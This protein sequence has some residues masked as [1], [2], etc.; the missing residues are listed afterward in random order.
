KLT[1]A[2]GVFELNVNNSWAVIQ[3]SMDGYVEK[4]V[5]VL[6]DQAMQ[7]KIYPVGYNSNFESTE[8][9]FGDN[10][11]LF[12]AGS[13]Q[14]AMINAWEQNSETITSY[15]QGKLS[16]VNVVRKSGTPSMGAN[17]FIRN[18]GSL[19]AQNQPLYIVD[20]VVYNAEMLTPSITSGHENNPLQHIDIRDIQ[21]VTVLKDAVST[22]IYGARAANGIVVINTTH[23]KELATKIDLQVR[24]GYNFSP[25]AIPMMKSYNYRSYLNDVLAT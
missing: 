3:V 22:A 9:V 7:I 17:L 10:S 20:G 12:A 6:F 18:I 25:K 21:D 5:P 24:T 4:S 19:Y 15:L 11:V 2:N 1:D 8:T 16:G 14:K 13:I 23:A